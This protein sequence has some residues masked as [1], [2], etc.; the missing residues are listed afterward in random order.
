[1]LRSVQDPC[2]SCDRTCSPEF[3]TTFHGSNVFSRCAAG[4]WCNQ[5]HED[6][7][8]H[9]SIAEGYGHTLSQGS[10]LFLLGV[11]WRHCIC[12]RHS[13]QNCSTPC[14]HPGRGTSLRLCQSLRCHS[15]DILTR[16]Q[17]PY[18]MDFSFHCPFSP[19]LL[20]RS[21]LESPWPPSHHCHSNWGGY[22]CI[23]HETCPSDTL[24]CTYCSLL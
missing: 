11:F 14:L 19:F 12:R 15:A 1:M 8:L 21:L 24:G 7:H 3:H 2:P 10:Y 18:V 20:L 9:L 6:L 23:S 5:V 16:V 17:V 4:G 13:P 22:R